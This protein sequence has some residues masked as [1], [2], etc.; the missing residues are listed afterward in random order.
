MS[1]GTEYFRQKKE[2]VGLKMKTTTTL[3][4]T[5]DPTLDSR[6]DTKFDGT[7]ITRTVYFYPA[8]FHGQYPILFTAC[9]LISRNLKDLTHPTQTTQ[10]KFMLHCQD[11]TQADI[12]DNLLWTFDDISFIPH[13]RIKG[14][15]PSSPA[16]PPALPPTSP[17]PFTSQ[18]PVLIRTNVFSGMDHPCSDTTLINLTHSVPP[19]FTLFNEI[20]EIV[21]EHEVEKAK[22]RNKFRFYREKG[23]TLR[24]EK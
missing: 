13:E 2:I 3:D 15:Q 12:I 8:K 6:L 9:H 16:S 20:F 4:M 17:L 19:D 21:P 24:W 7:I 14:A 18:M 1:I 23:C 11:E 5:L 22:A 10:K